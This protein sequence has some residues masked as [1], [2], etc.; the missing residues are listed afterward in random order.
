MRTTAAALALALASTAAWAE[1]PAC[2]RKAKGK[3]VEPPTLRKLLDCQAKARAGIDPRDEARW[4]RLEDF[5][6]GEVREYLAR[7][8]DR[9]SVDPDPPEPPRAKANATPAEPD[10]VQETGNEAAAKVR[11]QKKRSQDAARSNASGLSEEEQES[12]AAL[13]QKLWEMSKNGASAVTP[14]MAHEIVRHLQQ[15]QGGVS[16]DMK[17]LLDSLQRDGANLS[18]G[19]MLKVKKASRDAKKSGLDLGVDPNLEKWLL[20]PDTDPKAKQPQPA[21]D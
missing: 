6:K 5:Q 8:P 9:A 10:T 17:D 21:G 7:H 4:D 19:S 18:D 16:A 14:D 12:A 1:F 15:Q 3:F 13:Q 11:E 2:V 20:D